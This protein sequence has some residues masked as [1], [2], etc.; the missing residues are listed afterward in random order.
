MNI[1]CL[2]TELIIDV[3]RELLTLLLSSFLV[4]SLTVLKGLPIYSMFTDS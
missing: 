2:I 3:V 1:K 4:G